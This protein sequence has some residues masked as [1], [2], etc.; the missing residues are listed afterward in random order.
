MTTFDV[1]D[2]FNGPLFRIKADFTTLGQLIQAINKSNAAP[3]TYG[4]YT[5]QVIDSKDLL[6]IRPVDVLVG[7]VPIQRT[8][9]Y[10]KAFRD[11]RFVDPYI[12]VLFGHLFRAEVKRQARL[13]LFKVGCRFHCAITSHYFDRRVDIGAMSRRMREPG[14]HLLDLNT[15]SGTPPGL[16]VECSVSGKG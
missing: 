16:L 12:V 3:F 4:Q 6:W 9:T 7:S 11:Y 14:G 8:M 1:P 5:G 15:W 13:A 10:G 2:G